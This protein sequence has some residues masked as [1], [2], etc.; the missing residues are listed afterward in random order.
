LAVVTLVWCSGVLADDSAVL[1][2]IELL[3][4]G[5]VGKAGVAARI[6]GTNDT[7]YFNAGEAFPMASTYKVAIA[8]A[9][10][11]RVDKG[12]IALDDMHD[13][14]PESVVISAPIASHF[15]HPG[16]A[17]SVANL[18]E[19]MIVSSD[20]TA[21]DVLLDLVGGPAAVTEYVR[22][23]GIRELRVD[24]NT[25]TLLHDFYD[26]ESGL[27]N[28]AANALFAREHSDEVAAPRPDF[29]ADPRD[30]TTPRA[31]LDLLTLLSKHQALS[32]KSSEFL[33]DIMSRTHTAPGRIPALLPGGT[34][35]ARKTGTIGGV[36]N[37]VGYIKLPGDQRLAIA[38]YTK[39]SNTPAAD[40]DRVV[41]EIARTVYDYF[42]LLE[43]AV[44]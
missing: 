18:L 10:L 39:S 41:A 1:R 36:A 2:Q 7:L 14:P 19:V 5:K 17:L 23:I 12:E 22:S 9:I 33:F 38:I 34:A 26:R 15:G 29:E 40:R 35:I 44:Q 11:Q 31:M 37:D 43:P 8:M 28:L 32:E 25:A 20:N 3:A 30:Q 16:V 21:T 27:A 4:D 42:V 6:L 24:R 13:V